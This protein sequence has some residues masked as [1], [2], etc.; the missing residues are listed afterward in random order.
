MLFDDNTSKK[1]KISKIKFNIR[2][3]ISNWFLMF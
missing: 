3:D 2:G 1:D